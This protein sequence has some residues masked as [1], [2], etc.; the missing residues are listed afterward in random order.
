M[1]STTKAATHEIKDV[2]ALISLHMAIFLFGCSATFAKTLSLP[3]LMLVAGRTGF[4]TLALGVFLQGQVFKISQKLFIFLFLTAALLAAHWLSFFQSI[5]VSNVT[6]CLLAFSTFPIFVACIEPFIF[7]E[8]Y[9]KSDFIFA[10]LALLGLWIL[11]Q[12]SST[13]NVKAGIG[14]AVLSGFFFAIILVLNRMLVKEV[15]VIKIV[16]WQNCLAT[17]LLLPFCTHLSFSTLNNFQWLGLALL[18][19]IFTALSHTLYTKSLTRVTARFA[20][21]TTLL[22]PVY[23]IIVAMF[24]LHERLN[25]QTCLGGGIILAV[26][27]TLTYQRIK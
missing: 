2:K 24:Y 17:L 27:M 12:P 3:A 11:Y 20:A 25:I 21:I 22:E 6:L 19:I 13:G 4:A 9:Q 7:K 10:L 14:Y 16:F 26:M 23:G 8:K 1:D 15:A 5:I 18:G